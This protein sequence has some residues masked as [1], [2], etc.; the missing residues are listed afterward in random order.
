MHTLVAGGEV[1]AA[2]G[3]RGELAGA[4]LAYQ[5]QARADAIAIARGANGVD[6]EPVI[7]ASLI[8]E[9]H[10]FPVE[11]T[12][13]NVDLAVVV[14]IAEG[15]ASGRLQAPERLAALRGD[16]LEAAP[17]IAQKQERFEIAHVALEIRDK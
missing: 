6:G 9:K 2:G 5:V 3:H 12:D 15:R 16:V 1:T 7:G 14:E 4:G 8:V 17:H 13:S 11:A 10:R